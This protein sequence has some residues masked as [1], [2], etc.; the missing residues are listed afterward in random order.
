LLQWL[1]IRHRV[2]TIRLKFPHAR[3]AIVK[4]LDMMYDDLV[5]FMRSVAYKPM[6]RDMTDNPKARSLQ[7]KPALVGQSSDSTAG[8]ARCCR[9]FITCTG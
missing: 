1:W 6:S 9:P 8:H 7:G 4:G 3:G 5:D 2:R